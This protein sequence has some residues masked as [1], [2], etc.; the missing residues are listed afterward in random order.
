M[1]GGYL[2]GA[3]EY[4]LDQLVL[5]HFKA[6]HL[7]RANRRCRPRHLEHHRRLSHRGTRRQD[8]ELAGAEPSTRVGIERSEAGRNPARLALFPG[9]LALLNLIGKAVD[10]VTDFPRALAPLR[11]IHDV[12]ELPGR[13][14]EIVH[15]HLAACTLH[16]IEGKHI[17][18]A[19]QRKAF[20]GSQMRLCRVPIFCRISD[21]AAIGRPV[22]PAK[23]RGQLHGLAGIVHLLDHGPDP[24]GR[25]VCEA[26]LGQHLGSFVHQLGVAA[27]DDVRKNLVLGIYGDG[28]RVLFQSDGLVIWSHRKSSNLV[29]LGRVVVSS[30][31]VPAPP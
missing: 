17:G 31:W 6:E 30:F 26:L 23:H 21:Y 11:P 18:T 15:G 7:R 9:R 12:R 14:G 8:D 29:T 1:L 2:P 27:A 19:A 28:H 25:I 24:A 5:R 4:L 13:F 22:N 16:D 20:K 10:H 3:A